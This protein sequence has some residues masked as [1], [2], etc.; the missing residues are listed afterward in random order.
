[1]SSASNVIMPRVRYRH[2]MYSGRNQYV[3]KPIE[4]YVKKTTG[5]FVSSVTPGEIGDFLFSY[6]L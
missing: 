2:R 5:V 1:M 6:T 3:K 4:N